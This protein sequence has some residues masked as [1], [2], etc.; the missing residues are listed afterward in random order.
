MIEENRRHAVIALKVLRTTIFGAALASALTVSVTA[1]AEARGDGGSIAGSW[2]GGGIVSYA[3]GQRE[4]ARCRASYS[5]GGGSVVMNGECATPSGS[6]FQSA[7]L[8]RV[9][10]N[11]Y[12]GS[13]F[14]SQYNT[15]GSIYVTVRGNS[16][17]VNLRSSNGSASLTL[18]H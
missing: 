10:A 5:G 17:S 12:A 16:Q 15:S 9:G 11:S 2:S 3:S 8:R 4:R 14:N 6:V 1:F 7:R 18:R 13:F